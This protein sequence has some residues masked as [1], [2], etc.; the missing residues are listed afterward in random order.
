MTV[1]TAD[2][3]ATI[4]A[5]PVGHAAETG[6]MHLPVSLFATVMGLGGFTLALTLGERTLGLPHIASVAVFILALATFV[7]V[8]AVY[9]TKLLRH[10]D[11]VNGEWRHPVR[12]AFFPAIS[13]G[14][15]LLAAGAVEHLPAIAPA[16]WIAGFSLQSVLTLAVIATWIGPRPFQLPQVGPAWFIPAVGNVVVPIAG[17]PLGFADLSWISFSAGMIFWLLLLALVFHRLVISEPLPPR[18]QPTLAI[19]IAPPAVAFLSLIRLD[20][21]ADGAARLLGGMTFVFAAI[22]ATQLPRMLKAP[23]SVAWWA[24]SFPLAALTLATMRYGEMIGQPWLVTVG[25]GLLALLTVLIAVLVVRTLRLVLR[26]DL[27]R[28]E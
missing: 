2:Q 12:L 19:L 3:P 11:A 18:L 5:A 1:T 6:L 4:A 17:V 16:L 24:M 26:G 22:V 13:I 10:P 21:S 9:A 20:P 27:L 14:L 7:M 25:Q 23:F 15:L 28:A 8:L